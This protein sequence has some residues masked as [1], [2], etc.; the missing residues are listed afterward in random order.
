MKYIENYYKKQQIGGMSDEQSPIDV[1]QTP[2]SSQH[3][4]HDAQHPP[5]KSTSTLGGNPNG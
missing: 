4:M 2:P 1:M 5:Q 3:N